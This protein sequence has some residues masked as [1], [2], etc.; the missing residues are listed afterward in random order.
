MKKILYSAILILSIQSISAQNIIDFFY[1]IPSSYVDELSYL[2][3]KTLVK[4]KTLTK[5]GDKKF[6]VEID[7]KNGYLRLSQNYT[8]G[9]SGYAI[10]EM[11]YW[12]L[13]GKKLI[14]LSTVFG[15]NGGFF[16][17]NFKLFEYKND[18]LTEVRTGYLK[19][20]TSNFDVFINNLVSEFTKT[21]TKQSIK[22]NLTQSQF[23]IELPRNGKNMTVSFEENPMSSPEYFEKEYGKYLNF[24]KKIYKWNVQKEVFE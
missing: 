3:K 15:S 20:Y 23:T 5:Y 22:E 9:L 24:R 2:E 1:S 8:D 10:Y 12:N 14:A 11:A 7:T 18:N 21:N 13:K 17:Q 6:S 19:S 4:N 16:Q